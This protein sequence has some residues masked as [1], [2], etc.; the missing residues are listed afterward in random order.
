MISLDLDPGDNTGGILLIL[1]PDEDIRPDKRPLKRRAIK[2]SLECGC[3]EKSKNKI[4][5]TEE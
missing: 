4:I 1:S 3:G 2:K 5:K